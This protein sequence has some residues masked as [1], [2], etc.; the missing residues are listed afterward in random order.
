[1]GHNLGLS[2]DRRTGEDYYGGVGSGVSSWGVRCWGNAARLCEKVGM[3]KG[4]RTDERT[5]P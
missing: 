2:H 1:M 3:L 4:A 5:A